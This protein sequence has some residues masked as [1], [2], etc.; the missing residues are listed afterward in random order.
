MNVLLVI[1]EIAVGAVLLGTAFAML[2]VRRMVPLALLEP[3]R[4]R[5][6]RLAVALVTG[7][8]GIAM[9][10][11]TAVPFL[12]FFAAAASVLA[13]GVLAVVARRP[14]SSRV[15]LVIV[16]AAATAAMQPL[17][18]KVLALPRA[19]TLPYRPVAAT[20]IKTYPAG[21]GF[22]SVRAGPDGTLYLA[23]NRGLDFTSGAWYRE[24]VGHVI[25]RRP[26]GSERVLFTTPRGSTAGALALAPDRTIYMASMGDRPGIWRIAADGTAARLATLPRGSWP[27]GLAFG[28]DGL[29]YAADSNRAQVWR[30]DPRTGRY[31][32]ALH[33]R[34]L[35]SRPIVALAP[36][37]NGLHFAGAEMIVTVSDSTAVLAY[38]LGRDGRFA[39]P[40]LLARG[41]PGDDFAIGRDGSLFITTHPYDTVVRVAS[42]GRR[43]VVGD[44]RQHIVGATDASFGTGPTD[45]DTLYVATDGG[46]FTAG[47]AARGQLVALR[48]YG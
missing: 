7:V 34:R 48:P 27:N 15:A 24:A 33:D 21:T 47:A 8:P 35:A 36:G 42:D 44:A 5:G 13:A 38:R 12:A 16:A 45:R 40:R 43:T 2:G 37:A 18:L 41:I 4:R 6:L 14:H 32:V 26:D 39:P 25:E 29:L 19:D 20:A 31:A 17:G 30:I 46:A 23:A 10:A 22:E 3:G 28:P 11:A 9:I 1:L